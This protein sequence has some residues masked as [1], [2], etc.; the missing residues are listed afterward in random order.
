[1]RKLPLF[2]LLALMGCAAPALRSAA[3][4]PA[5]QA[6]YK[7]DLASV[8]LN[9][10]EA[11]TAVA[12]YREALALESA[13]LEQALYHQG[14][15]Q[16]YA[17]RN[18]A[19]PA[20][21]HLDQAL[22]IY[23]AVIRSSPQGAAQFLE[24]YVRIAPRERS[25]AVVDDVVAAHAE[26]S[27]PQALVW[28]ANVYLAME[29]PADALRLY[30]RAESKAPAPEAKGQLKLAQALLLARLKMIDKAET[31]YRGLIKEGP[32]EIADAAQRNLLVLYAGQGRL[33][34]VRLV[35]R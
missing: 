13:P 34:K 21:E 6:R 33:D 19:A 9:Y 20:R 14:L 27:D 2:S 22:A 1:M 3:L 12:L 11:E 35:E 17:A 16:A 18:A 31:I 10:G 24:R 7:A 28:L 29:S 30:E 25:K 8:H 23:E 5:V 4:P 32:K 26:K 15:A